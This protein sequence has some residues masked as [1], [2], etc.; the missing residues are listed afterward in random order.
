TEDPRGARGGGRRGGAVRM[1]GVTLLPVGDRGWL[2]ELADNAAARRVARRLRH[3]L[4][5]LVE[6]VPGDRT[7]LAVGEVPRDTLRRVA[8]AALADA[9]EEP[10][11]K[12]VEIAVRYDGPDLGEVARL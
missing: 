10:D 7:V 2:L 6:V 8:E 9:L 12:A 1:T 5:A 11:A 3:E 4:P